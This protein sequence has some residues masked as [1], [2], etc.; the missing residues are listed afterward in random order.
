MQSFLVYTVEYPVCVTHIC[1]G[2]H[3]RRIGPRSFCTDVLPRPRANIPQCG[4]RARL[5]RGYSFR[6]GPC[7]FS[8]KL[9]R[10]S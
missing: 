3:T 10:L 5:V 2:I 1:F 4:T 7:L 8:W 9:K 6:S